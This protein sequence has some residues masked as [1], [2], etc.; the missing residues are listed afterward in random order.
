MKWSWKYI[1]IIIKFRRKIIKNKVWVKKNTK[2]G[3]K[4]SV[5]EKN[6]NQPTSDKTNISL[7][8]LD[9]IY[10]IF[11]ILFTI[12]LNN[13]KDVINYCRHHCYADATQLFKQTKINEIKECIDIINY[14]L[15]NVANFSI[16]NCL[17]IN[18]DKCHFI[19]L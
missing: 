16:N 10:V 11:I 6:M 1:I 19:I 12:L 8:T 9:K 13:I 15:D 4:L 17:Q 14:D 7:P 18:A 3:K 2:Q 5:D